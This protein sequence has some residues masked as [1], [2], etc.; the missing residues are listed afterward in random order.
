M[1][2]SEISDYFICHPDR[3]EAQRSE[4]VCCCWAERSRTMPRRL[5][6]DSGFFAVQAA[7][8]R[9]A[10]GNPQQN[11]RS[12][13]FARL[14]FAPVGMTVFIYF[15]AFSSSSSSSLLTKS[16]ACPRTV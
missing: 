3:S 5:L 8:T 1:S 12:L 2:G 16:A 7:T 4:L 14:R 10:V 11:T 6:G 13:H 15:E 9:D